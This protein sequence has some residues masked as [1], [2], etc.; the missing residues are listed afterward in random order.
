M[1]INFIPSGLAKKNMSKL[2][3]KDEQEKDIIQELYSAPVKDY[4]VTFKYYNLSKPEQIEKLEFKQIDSEPFFP[5]I[6][7]F[8]EF[9]NQRMKGKFKFIDYEVVDCFTPGPRYQTD[10]ETEFKIH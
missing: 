10:I 9:C 4:V 5:R 8:Y 1:N 6:N 7:R 3:S 2:F